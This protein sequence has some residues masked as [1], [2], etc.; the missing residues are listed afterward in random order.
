MEWIIRDYTAKESIILDPFFGSGTTGV[1]A[2]RLGRKWI[3][4]EISEQYCE[5]A[6]KRLEAEKQGITVKEL[7]KGQ[8]SLFGIKD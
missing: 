5:I 1:A 2:Q 4:I 8:K 3:G 7:D 6:A